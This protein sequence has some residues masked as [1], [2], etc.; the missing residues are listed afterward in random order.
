MYQNWLHGLHGPRGVCKVQI[1]DGCMNPI[2]HNV[3]A[4]V[5]C[6][7]ADCMDHRSHVPLFCT[8]HM[9]REVVWWTTYS[10]RWV[11]ENQVWCRKWA[12]IKFLAFFFNK[13][14][15]C[16]DAEKLFI[17]KQQKVTVNLQRLFHKSILPLTSLAPWSQLTTLD[18]FYWI[19]AMIWTVDHEYFKLTGTRQWYLTLVRDHL[20]MCSANEK[21]YYIVKSSLIGT[22]HTQ[23][24]PRWV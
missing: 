16:L 15:K 11:H 3:S 6:T 1:E 19:R 22:A 23:N 10:M 13:I 20:C 24:D 21:W 12:K 14:Q 18:V 4:W 7:K 8:D 17:L 9:C 5:T 2:Y